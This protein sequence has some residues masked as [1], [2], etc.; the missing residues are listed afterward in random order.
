MGDE[1]SSK[2]MHT[3]SAPLSNIELESLNIAISDLNLAKRQVL[4]KNLNNRRASQGITI[5][6]PE[7]SESSP[8]KKKS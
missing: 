3:S 8:S 6:E 4:T 5:T 7:I 1:A 2:V